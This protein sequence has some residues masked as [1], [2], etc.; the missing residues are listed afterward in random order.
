MQHFQPDAIATPLQPARDTVIREAQNKVIERMKADPDGN[1]ATI[2]TTGRVEDGLA[3]AVQ[4]GK[5]SAM[6]DLGRGMGGDASAPSPGFY[7]RAAV[8]GCVAIAVKMLAAREGAVFRSV[9]VT[10]ETDF[11]DGTLFGLGP[12]SAA[13]TET[14]VNIAI[15]SAESENRIAEIVDRALA[16]DPW[17]LALRDAQTVIPSLTVVEE[18]QPA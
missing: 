15:D 4:Q 9:E 14:R 3:G 18:A 1:Y 11:D 7:A 8:A 5:F 10:V 6:M 16:M 17:Y 13:P 12:R 2:V